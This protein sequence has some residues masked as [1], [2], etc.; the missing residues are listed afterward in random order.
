MESDQIPGKDPRQI[1]MLLML[2][3]ISLPALFAW[4][5]LLPGYA[6]STRNAAFAYAFLPVVAAIALSLLVEFAQ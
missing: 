1:N 5:L 4:F 2:G 6:R 3:L